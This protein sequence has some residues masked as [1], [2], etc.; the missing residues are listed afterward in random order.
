LAI[1]RA[2]R[3]DN[4]FTQIRNDVLRDDRLSYRARGVL[5]VI[6]SHADGWS[7]SSEAIATAGREGRDAIRTAL[8]ELEDAGYLCREKRQDSQGR[9]A[10]HQVIYDAPHLDAQ[11]A[12]FAAPTTDSQASVYQ[13]SVSQAP[14][15]DHEEQ[16]SPAE[17]GE[18]PKPPADV[19]AS[20]VWDHTQGMVNY[21]AI[22]QV[23]G[24]ALKVKDATPEKITAAMTKLYDD[25]RPITLTTVGQTLSRGSFK[26]AGQDHWAKGGEF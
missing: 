14:I 16:P 21:M 2:A 10:T 24:R 7:T 12:L 3:P 11:P 15:E 26:D 23:A 8:Q 20:A 17:K 13:S 25:G 4:H 22:R 5:A 1:H 18:K 6:L 9:W 19:I